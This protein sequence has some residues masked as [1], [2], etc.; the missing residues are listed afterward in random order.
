MT[1]DYGIIP[2]PK[3]DEAQKEYV[4]LSH[5]SGTVICVPATTSDARMEYV[6]AVLEATMAESYRSVVP[7]FIEASLKHKYSRDEASAKTVDLIISTISKNTLDEYS[8]YVN[9][10]YTSV[11]VKPAVNSG[12]FASSYQKVREAAQKSWDK[13]IAEMMNTGK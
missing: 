9:D 13:T 2:F 8:V 10:M 3:L 11:L 1:D 7:K 12:A 6:G 4:T 5:N